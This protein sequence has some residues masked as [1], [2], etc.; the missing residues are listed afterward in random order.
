MLHNSIFAHSIRATRRADAEAQVSLVA[1][2]RWFDGEGD[3]DKNANTQKKDEKANVKP[4][5]QNTG[6]SSG[7]TGGQAAGGDTHDMSITLTTAAFEERL[8]RAKATALSELL[9]ALGIENTDALKQRLQKAQELEDAGKTELEKAQSAL[10]KANDRIQELDTELEQE[11]AQRRADNRNR[12]FE[13]LAKKVGARKP[14]YVLV[15]AEKLHAD[16]FAR[17]INE[18]GEPDE[19]VINKILTKM[20]ETDKELFGSVNPSVP[21]NSGA[22]AIVTDE[23]LRKSAKQA[24]RRAFRG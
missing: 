1:R 22:S 3:G 4:D 12:K 18:A 13:E 6:T 5:Q 23:N 17:T 9:K 7:Q 16:L 21:S 8:E 11:R 10:K 14:D 20:R 19:T 15:L 24:N 2:R